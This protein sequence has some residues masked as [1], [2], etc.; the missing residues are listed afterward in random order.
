MSPS[1]YSNEDIE[2]KSSL[3]IKR[4]NIQMGKGFA[5]SVKEEKYYKKLVNLQMK[6]E[7]TLLNYLDYCKESDI[8]YE[9]LWQQKL[10]SRL[11]WLKQRLTQQILHIDFDK[12]YQ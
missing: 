2:F 8:L 6:T 9:C 1:F 4:S 3:D 11:R 12:F 5:R 10:L 7:K